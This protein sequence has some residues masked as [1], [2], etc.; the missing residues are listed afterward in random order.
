[1]RRALALLLLL[2]LFA[3]PALAASTPVHDAAVSALDASA[4]KTGNGW[5]KAI[6]AASTVLPE[7][8]R[9]DGSISVTVMI[10]A[11][12]K[13]LDKTPLI[14][15]LAFLKAGTE[16]DSE[17]FTLT[18][19]M[20]GDKPDWQTGPRNAWQRIKAKAVTAGNVFNGKIFAALLKD[21]LLPQQPTDAMVTGYAAAMNI[22]E[23]MARE[24]LLLFAR[25]IELTGADARKGP[26]GATVAIRIRDLS[27]L[28]K[29]RKA[30]L[31][32]VLAQTTGASAMTRD[33][34]N[35]VLC[36]ALREQLATYTEKKSALTKKKLKTDLAALVNLNW[37][38]SDGWIGALN[39]LNSQ[40]DTL[41]DSWA[42]TAKTMPFYPAINQP[43]SGLLYGEGDES[44]VLLAL[45]NGG[46]G[47][48]FVRIYQNGRE[49][50]RC[51]VHDQNPCYI[52]LQS[53]RYDLVY[54]AGETWSGQRYLFGDKTTCAAVS[55]DLNDTPAA[56]LL[57]TATPDGSLPVRE[58]S[59]DDVAVAS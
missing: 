10:P 27:G 42:S 28:V 59:F 29:R 17:S 40:L 46:S 14:E 57:L 12:P 39:S 20:A 51:Y 47:S 58:A 53:G 16:V 1:M 23:S 36:G 50:A 22:S 32:Q 2:I 52:R 8:V 3:L 55:V 48:R 37:S 18:A 34:L 15:Q 11:V 49:K 13:K 38:A 9:P 56:E 24:R 21:A 41:L 33:E 45:K 54:A 26:G 43:V 31:D 7:E 25:L 35:A 44:G 6:Y 30:V 4:A 5:A 19:S